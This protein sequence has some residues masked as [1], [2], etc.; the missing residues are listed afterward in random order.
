MLIQHI[1]RAKNVPLTEK[2]A[3]G[4]YTKYPR[5]CYTFLNFACE[6]F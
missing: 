4:I 3:K 6:H 1:F 5:N 2:I